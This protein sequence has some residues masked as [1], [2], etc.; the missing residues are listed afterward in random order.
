[1]IAAPRQSPLA[2]VR[3]RSLVSALARARADRAGDVAAETFVGRRRNG[4]LDLREVLPIDAADNARDIRWP[5]MDV[6]AGDRVAAG[7]GGLDSR[8]RPARD[9]ADVRRLGGAASVF[10]SVTSHAVDKGAFAIAIHFVHQVGGGHV[11][12]R[13]GLVADR[14]DAT[15]MPDA[16]W[17]RAAT[18]RVSAIAGWSVAAVGRD[19]RDQSVGCAGIAARSA[20]EL[21]LRTDAA[22]EGR[23]GGDGDPD[24]RL[25][26]ISTGGVGRTNRRRARSLIRNVAVE[27]A[28]LGSSA[29]MVGGTGQYT[30]AAL[31]NGRLGN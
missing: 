15:D 22:V 20:G 9:V 8:A 7:S 2:M 27:C 5:S 24:W 26:P 29:R 6:A 19:R 30:A 3:G 31:S 4:G 18:S 23:H 21:D 10:Q 1:M 13:A 25:Q 11:D 12:R 17:L 14:R 28:L 16:D